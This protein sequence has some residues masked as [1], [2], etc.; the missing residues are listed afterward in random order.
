MFSLLDLNSQPLSHWHWTFIAERALATNKH[1]I[2]QTWTHA[3]W[4]A[5][6][7]TSTEE[8]RCFSNTVAL[9]RG[10]WSRR[11]GSAPGRALGMSVPLEVS[12]MHGATPQQQCYTVTSP[13]SLRPGHTRPCGK[14]RQ[15]RQRSP[16]FQPSIASNLPH[17]DFAMV[18]IDRV[19]LRG[20]SVIWSA[21]GG[22]GS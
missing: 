17:C 8:Q 22:I 19:C 9:C 1:E 16:P 6:L 20:L 11:F 2:T 12:R 7:N 14:R 3:G 18:L 10:R 15:D 21:H 4:S 5:R 13:A